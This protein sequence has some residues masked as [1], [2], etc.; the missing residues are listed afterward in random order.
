MLIV[1]A[2]VLLIAGCG[3]KKGVVENQNEPTISSEVE[4]RGG[5]IASG[6]GYGFSEFILEIDVDG[7]DAIDI[8]YEVNKQ[9]D[10]FE[11]EYEN[12]IENFHLRDEEAM[13]AIDEFFLEVRISKDTPKEKA[14]NEILQHLNV[15]GY[16][17]FELDITFVEL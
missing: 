8:G 1:F 9:N 7:I 6:D 14:K 11:A 12:N 16:S 3:N 13:N 15:E 4:D 10:K 5:S 17:K 2:S